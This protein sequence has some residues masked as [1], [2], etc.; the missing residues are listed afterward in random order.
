[1][2]L[3]LRELPRRADGELRATARSQEGVAVSSDGDHGSC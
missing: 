1:M 3:W 2:E